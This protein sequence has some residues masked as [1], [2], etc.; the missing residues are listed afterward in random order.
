MFVLNDDNVFLESN[1]MAQL[2]RQQKIENK[3]THKLFRVFRGQGL[4]Q[5]NFEK[6]KFGFTPHF[7]SLWGF[8]L[9]PNSAKSVPGPNLAEISRFWEMAHF[10]LFWTYFLGAFR[11]HVFLMMQ[12]LPSSHL[13]VNL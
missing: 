10:C 13:T 3:V 6:M 12:L 2:Y 7:W 11:D 8:S 9:T 4:S 5:E 1:S